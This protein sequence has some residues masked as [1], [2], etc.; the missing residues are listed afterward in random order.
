M[1]WR[2][3]DG[4]AVTVAI[5]ATRSQ[6]ISPRNLKH[7]FNQAGWTW[8]SYK[9][10]HEIFSPT[11]P[12]LPVRGVDPELDRVMSAKEE[13]PMAQILMDRGNATP[14]EGSTPAQGMASK[15]PEPSPAAEHREGKIADADPCAV[16]AAMLPLPKPRR[17]PARKPKTYVTPALMEIVVSRLIKKHARTDISEA[18]G[19][20]TSTITQISQGRHHLLTSEQHAALRA[21]R[22]GLLRHNPQVNRHQPEATPV[23]AIPVVARPPAPVPEPAPSAAPP[24]WTAKELVGLLRDAMKREKIRELLIA[25]DAKGELRCNITRIAE[26]EW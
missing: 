7:I 16:Q 14:I 10:A 9:R 4:R 19:L 11:M 26:E 2:H 1:Q 24:I 18:T 5:G 13:T 3:P 25:P 17:G 6:Q 21:S 15:A 8:A 22:A 23:P 20:S 12:G